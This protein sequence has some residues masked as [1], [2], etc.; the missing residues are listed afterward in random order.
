MCQE[1]SVPKSSN[2]FMSNYSKS[3]VITQHISRRLALRLRGEVREI[4][5][6]TDLRDINFARG[7]V[8]Q[9][10]DKETETEFQVNRQVQEY[11]IGTKA[12]RLMMIAAT[13]LLPHL[14]IMRLH[15]LLVD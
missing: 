9:L 13:A 14:Q 3:S 10:N 6:Q 2:F 4:D 1:M 15:W 11:F 5:E 12:Q 8:E 7:A